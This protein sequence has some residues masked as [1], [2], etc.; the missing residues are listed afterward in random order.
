MPA[1]AQWARTYPKRGWS[2]ARANISS[3]FLQQ[4]V[5]Q[6]R[7]PDAGLGQPLLRPREIFRGIGAP[8]FR[9][10]GEVVDVI[11]RQGMALRGPVD[12]SAAGHFLPVEPPG[13]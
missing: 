3:L 10:L 4:L 5:Q 8:D 1:P 12:R 11:S 9:C 6:C 7:Q 13:G 2:G